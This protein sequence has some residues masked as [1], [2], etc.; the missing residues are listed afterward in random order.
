MIFKPH[1]LCHIHILS[2]LTSIQIKEIRWLDIYFLAKN[3]DLSAL[4]YFAHKWDHANL[5]RPENTEREWHGCRSQWVQSISKGALRLSCKCVFMRNSFTFLNFAVTFLRMI[6]CK[7]RYRTHAIITCSW[8][9]TAHNYKPPILDPKI[10]EFPYLVHKLSVTVTALQYKPQWKM[11]WKIYK[12]RV[13]MACVQYMKIM[14]LS[15]K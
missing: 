5:Q 9:E 4:T 14:K 13:I 2:A 12:P 15:H 6:L 11:G 10:E 1:Y 7:R 3:Y 8:F